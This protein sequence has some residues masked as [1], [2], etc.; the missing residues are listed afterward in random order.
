VIGAD[1]NSLLALSNGLFSA[2]RAVIDLGLTV[3]FGNAHVTEA[4]GCYL[5]VVI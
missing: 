5:W 1:W 3:F 4:L 2:E